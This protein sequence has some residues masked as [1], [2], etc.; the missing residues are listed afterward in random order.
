MGMYRVLEDYAG[1]Y[2]GIQ[3]YIRVYKGIWDHIRALS[4]KGMEKKMEKTIGLRV[5][6]FL[7]G[8]L[9]FRETDKKTV[10]RDMEGLKSTCCL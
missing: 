7:F 9:S 6:E 4:F 2:N 5:Y 10:R 8:A 1:V 3:G